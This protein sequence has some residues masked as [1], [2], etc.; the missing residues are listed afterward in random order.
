MLLILD[1]RSRWFLWRI[2]LILMLT[3]LT[4]VLPMYQIHL[5]ILGQR[6]RWEQKHAIAIT[7]LIWVVYFWAFWKVGA[8]FPIMSNHK[9]KH[10]TPILLM[11]AGFFSIE[12][13]MGRVGV[14]GVTLMAILSG[15][16]AV[17]APYTYLL[18]FL[19]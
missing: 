5:L 17:S 8:P 3:L 4:T 10:K 16:G 14:I 9:S 1:D 18:Y 13:I 19:R 15:F 2:S 6:H 7:V 12:Q 11:H